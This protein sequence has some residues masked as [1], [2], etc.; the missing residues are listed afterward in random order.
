MQPRPS[1]GQIVLMAHYRATCEQGTPQPRRAQP[2]LVH[3]TFG[4]GQVSYLAASIGQSYDQHQYS[5]PYLRRANER[6]VQV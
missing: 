5:C 4:N 6:T 1:T 3:N 2:F